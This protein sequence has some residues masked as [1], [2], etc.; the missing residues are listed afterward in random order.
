MDN[1]YIC[2]GCGDK[3]SDPSQDFLCIWCNNR[4]QLEKTKW[5]TSVGYKSSGL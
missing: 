3:F 5:V 1:Y 4:F 2:N